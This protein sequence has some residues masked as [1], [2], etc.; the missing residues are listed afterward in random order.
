LTDNIFTNYIR[1]HFSTAIICGDISDHFPVAVR[2]ELKVVKIKVCNFQTSRSFFYPVSI[3]NFKIRLMNYDW[4]TIDY[5]LSVSNDPFS[6]LERIVCGVL[7][8]SIAYLG[9]FYS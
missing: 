7:Q 1:N 5:S 8:G 9:Q 4:D 6:P 3:D 2:I